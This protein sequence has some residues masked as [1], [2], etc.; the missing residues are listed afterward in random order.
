MCFYCY[1]RLK[2][3]K[4]IKSISQGNLVFSAWTTRLTFGICVM[5][6]NKPNKKRTGSCLVKY[7]IKCLKQRQCNKTLVA[8]SCKSALWVKYQKAATC[9]ESNYTQCAELLASCRCRPGIWEKSGPPMIGHS[10]YCQKRKEKSDILGSCTV[11]QH[12]AFQR[13]LV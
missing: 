7:F 5:G 13:L 4:Y 9:D 10:Q 1:V 3:E 8:L 12:Q 11:L 6:K 2:G